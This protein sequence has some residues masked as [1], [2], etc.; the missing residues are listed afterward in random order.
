MSNIQ[1]WRSNSEIIIQDE[2]NI[3]EVVDYAKQL[4]PA[5][6]KQLITAF[7]SGNYQMLS[8]YVWTKTISALKS[9]LTKMG[10]AFVGEMLDRPDINESTNLQNAITESETI[11]LAENMGIIG[12]KVAFRLRHAM[13]LLTYFNNPDAEDIEES[14]FTKVD[15]VQILISCIK[16]VLG[17]DN[18][19]LRIDFKQFRNS[20]EESVLTSESPNIVK[21]IQGPLFFKRATIKIL[22]SIIKS[23]SGAQLENA[24]ANSNLIIPN[25]WSDLR[26]PEKW[27]IG[28]C[29]AELFT[30]GKST[31]VNGLKQTL[32]KV[33]GFDFVPEDLRSTSFIKA[34]NEIIQ[35]HEG[36][37]NYYYEPAPTKTLRDMGSIIPMPAFPICMSAVLTIRMGNLYG[38]SWDAQGPADAILSTLGADKWIYYFEECLPNDSRVI[39]KLTQG[40]PRE[41]WVDLIRN[42]EEIEDIIESLQNPTIKYLLI[43]SQ[44]GNHT[45]IETLAQKL[46]DEAS[47]S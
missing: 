38:Y 22:L 47:I 16:G 1:P 31:A 24:L 14:D 2:S 18:I 6:K 8:S 3:S 44:K 25:I 40:K 20:L 9:Y 19:E 32:L 21:L 11:T 26:Q 35:A 27:Q 15:A 39:Y 34:A 23:R 37:N 43:A 7:N 30:E 13:D 4:K 28:R 17:Q 29:Y 12:S 5:D 33:R 42:N 41:R 10:A 36:I 46:N 45:R